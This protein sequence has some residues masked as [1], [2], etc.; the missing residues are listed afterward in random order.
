MHNDFLPGL[1]PYD[2]RSSDTDFSDRLQVS[3]LFAL[4]QE[5]A[6]RHAEQI[7]IGTRL[8][9][10]LDLSWMLSRT[11]VRLESLPHWGDQIW[12][13]TWSR[14]A[15][16]LL[17]ERDYEFISGDPDNR[18]F[19]RA[20]S[21][22]LVVRRDNHRP[23]RPE[24]VL[25]AAQLPVHPEAPA[26]FD[27]P[28]P[29]IESQIGPANQDTPGRKPDLLKYADFSEIDRNRH[30]NN[31]R[32]IAWCMDAAYAA[33]FG[34]LQSLT[35]PGTR[36]LELRALDIN[37]LSEIRPG[38]RVQLFVDRKH[39]DS[40]G[41]IIVEGLKSELLTASFRARMQFE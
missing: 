37:Y 26:V 5:S 13:R 17:F 9:D 31:T 33:L 34:G 18:P 3:T 36:A 15:R 24:I 23:Q 21:E 22:W 16:R 10:A 11:S 39:P 28:S 20:T 29:K 27:F 25:T 7:G 2:I 8:L 14:G 41:T 32:Y 19:G 1:Y 35:D 12:I 6:Y 4:M 38:D 40:P 30:V